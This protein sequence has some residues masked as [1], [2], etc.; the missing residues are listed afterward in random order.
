MFTITFIVSQDGIPTDI[1]SSSNQNIPTRT[2]PPINLIATGGQNEINLTWDGPDE[3]GDSAEVYLWVSDVT[4]DNIEI[5]IFNSAGL[6]GFQFNINIDETLNAEL[7]GPGIGGIAQQNGLMVPTNSDG[8]VLGF[9]LLGSFIQPGEGILTNIPWTHEDGDGF[10]DLS[11]TYVSSSYDGNGLSTNSRPPYCFG[12]C[13]EQILTYNIYRDEIILVIEVEDTFYSD[14]ELGSSESYCYTVT[15]V[16]SDSESEFSNEACATTNLASPTNLLA[17]SAEWPTTHIQLSWD[18]SEGDDLLEYLI[19]KNGE[20]YT[21]T[22]DTFYADAETQHDVE[23]CYTV[24]A[25]YD[26]GESEPSNEA[27]A[28]WQ[29]CP[30]S[31]L[32]AIAG[33]GEVFIT[34]DEIS[35]DEHYNPFRIYTSNLFRDGELIASFDPNVFEYL[36][37]DVVNLEEYCYT[38]SASFTEGESPMSDPVCV[39]PAPNEAP[40]NLTAFPDD[41]Q[42]YLSWDAGS[43]NDM[44]YVIYLEGVQLGI[45]DE[46]SFID[47]IS[48]HCFGT[49]YI[50]T[51]M[52]D[53]GESGHSNEACI[54]WELNSIILWIETSGDDYN[55][56]MWTHSGAPTIGSGETI[57]EA[58]FI[59]SIP[60]DD[61]QN[62]NNFVND[63]DEECPYTGSLSPD[64][65]YA[66]IA[67][68]GEY[69][70][71]ICDSD[72]DTKLYIYDDTQNLI[73]CIDDSCNSP[74]GNPFR[75]DLNIS[76]TTEGWYYIVVDGYGSQAGNYNLSLTEGFLYSESIEDQPEKDDSTPYLD[77][78]NDNNFDSSQNGGSNRD[79]EGFEIYRDGQFIYLSAPDE[80]SFI[81]NDIGD[82]EHCY[83]VI[84]V[85]SDCTG[86]TSNE[87]CGPIGPLAMCPPEN[88]DVDVDDEIPVANLTW[89]PPGNCD[90]GG[91]GG[92]G[93]VLLT[94]LTDTW[95]SETSWNIIDSDGIYI[96]GIEAG[97]LVD[98]TLYTWDIDLEAGAYTFTILD[99][100]GDGIYCSDGGYYQIDVNGVTIGGG[101]GIG[102]DFGSGISHDFTAEGELLSNSE[103]HYDTPIQGQKG[104][105]RYNMTGRQNIETINF[106]NESPR[107]DRLN[108]YRIFRDGNEI[109]NVGADETEYY[110]YDMAYDIEHCWHMLAV[111]ED[112]TSNITDVI[113]YSPIE[114]P[115]ISQLYFEEGFIESGESGELDINLINI[116]DI[117]G[118]QFAIT[119]LPDLLTVTDVEVTDRSSSFVVEFNEMGDGSIFIVGFSLTGGVITIGEGP[120]LTLTI[121]ADIVEDQ[122]DVVINFDEIFFGGLQ[123]ELITTLGH[124]STI[125]ILPYTPFELIIGDASTTVGDTVIF[126]ISLTNEMN[127][128]GF[129]F[130]LSFDSDI[131]TLVEV[132]PSERIPTWMIS[133]SLESGMIIG[134]P[135]SGIISPGAGPILDVT[136]IGD[137]IG[138]TSACLSEILLGDMSGNQVFGN[139]QCGELVVEE[140]VL[141]E[142]PVINNIASGNDEIYFDWTWEASLQ[143][144]AE[145]NLSIISFE[146]N[147]LVIYMENDFGIPGYTLTLDSDIDGYILNDA[148]GGSSGSPGFLIVSN[149]E[150]MILLFS[151]GQVI[152]TGEGILV[153][154]DVTISGNEGCFSLS[155]PEF[156]D[157][158]GNS[159]SVDTG[160]PFCI[161]PDGIE[162]CTDLDALNFNPDATTDDDSCYYPTFNIYRDGELID[163]VIDVYS[164]FE[165]NLDPGYSHC[166]SITALDENGLESDFSNEACMDLTSNEFAPELFNGLP[167]M[168]GYFAPIIINDVIGIGLG[169]RDEIGIFDANGVIIGGDCWYETGEILVGSDIWTGDSLLISIIGAYE[170]CGFG[171]PGWLPGYLEGNTISFRYFGESTNTIYEAEPE[172]STGGGT[173]GEPITIVN[174]HIETNMITQSIVLDPFIN[175]G[176]STYVIADDMSCETIF[177]DDVFIARDDHGNFY[178]PEFNIYSLD[179]LSNLEG[180]AV[181]L[182]GSESHTID[183]TG[184]QIDP[185]TP[186]ALHPFVNN[187]L[188]YIVPTAMASEHALSSIADDIL[189][190]WNNQGE[191]IVPSYGL[192]FLNTFEP[193]KIYGTFLSGSESIEFSYPSPQLANISYNVWEELKP[194]MISQHY[195]V[196]KTGNVHPIVITDVQGDIQIGDE[197]AVYAEGVLVGATRIASLDLPIPI[198]AWGEIK[199]YGIDIPGYSTGDEIEFRIWSIEQNKELK[200]TA[201][202]DGKYFG[203]TP[204]TTGS[205]IVHS[206]DLIPTEFALNPAYPNP[207]N[208]ITT[209]SYDIALDGQ[210]KLAVYDLQG[211]LISELTNEIQ[212]AGNYSINWNANEFASGIYILRMTT[213]EYQSSQR[214]ILLK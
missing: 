55:E 85:F 181:F 28:M 81:D 43:T 91:G 54:E 36:D 207:F 108:G 86:P 68:T 156:S 32:T 143:S 160:Q 22:S 64:V 65:V 153:Y 41:N 103:F 40:I 114:E 148:Y 128:T 52:D 102:C 76:I 205:I 124:E 107:N 38:I 118:F 50:V 106:T 1:F 21:S 74:D 20:F 171:G 34:W 117:A 185:A 200:V 196:V 7:S 83:F 63:Y 175:N 167:S 51:S 90:D 80:N 56:L 35:C 133:F 127:I 67:E 186:L 42:I 174:L 170:G 178:V 46:T 169:F 136:I 204:L 44:Y 105:A 66:W 45:S 84:P 3:N 33:D 53:E 19:S 71:D 15:S 140:E 147:Q 101:P 37:T 184:T 141:V 11:I 49:C 58:I 159:L 150:G 30:P 59:T 137:V 155:S 26:T 173:F 210:V 79:L 24:S 12:D 18:T 194:A 4:E 211:R 131:A 97:T 23:Y 144:D 199:Q 132:L 89:D 208:P 121:E 165:A 180:Y 25:L 122:T 149:P 60:F 193:G 214:I 77:F 57:E 2:N 39:M 151:T 129:Q 168:T 177:G 92:G 120:I 162:G 62:T 69:H 166:Y 176:I 13:D 10:I 203:E 206:Q 116:L 14:T 31:S 119:D 201:N 192:W 87:A 202:L 72:Y 197:I 190:V 163:S 195:D 135:L 16:F 109:A 61:T 48:D 212:S 27:C 198:T 99:S 112:G 126:P 115:G 82:Y 213:S 209:I 164:L 110:D 75:S 95:A 142:A 47:D 111:Y 123:G 157:E 9:G 17:E 188:P 183:I 187:Y 191:F 88:F 138:N 113:C 78:R 8:L 6:Q 93:N 70:I 125:S 100:Y 29:L 130:M 5:S 94:I 145:V 73:D 189:I 104:Q 154:A 146:D 152:P 96:D 182:Q 179:T 158:N 161:S 172:Y 98:L 134:G 139:S